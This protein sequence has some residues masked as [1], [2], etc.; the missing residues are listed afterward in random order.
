MTIKTTI[1]CHPDMADYFKKIPFYNKH[2]VKSEIKLLK[3]H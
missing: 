3:K 1:K 2:T